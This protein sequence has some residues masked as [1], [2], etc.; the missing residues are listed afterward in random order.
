M[1]TLA[2]NR[3]ARFDYVILDSFE[4]GIE[5]LGVEVKSV[6]GGR[7]NLHGSYGLLRGNEAWLINAEIPAYQP[8]NAPPDFDSKRSRRL[9]LHRME[10]RMLT[11]KLQE[12]GLALIPLRAYQKNNVI[13]LELGI[14]KAKKKSDKRELLKKKASEREMRRVK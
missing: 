8:K 7:M 2:E 12:K 11:G 5:L 1:Q 4:V 14:A 10:I 6:K 3:R 13:K 9:L